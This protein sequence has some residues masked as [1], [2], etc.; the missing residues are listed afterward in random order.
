MHFFHFFEVQLFIGI[1]GNRIFLLLLLLHRVH[2]WLARFMMPVNIYFVRLLESTKIRRILFLFEI[3]VHII[4]I[5]IRLCVERLST[6]RKSCFLFQLLLFQV[7]FRLF[8]C[9][10]A[11]RSRKTHY[12]SSWESV[13]NNHTRFFSGSIHSVHDSSIHTRFLACLRYCF[14]VF[15][16]S[17]FSIFFCSVR[18]V[19]AL[20]SKKRNKME[21]NMLCNYHRCWETSRKWLR[22]RS[23]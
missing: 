1:H 5:W 22:L 18:L 9:I 4:F 20:K 2:S 19:R 7:T 15:F 8:L 14:N 16:F 23:E 10:L 6:Y 11:L 17:S 12:N 13:A 3:L 21:K